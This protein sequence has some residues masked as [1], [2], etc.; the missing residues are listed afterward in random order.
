[1]V[2]HFKL[3]GTQIDANLNDA[4]SVHLKSED[5]SEANLLEDNIDHDNIETSCRHYGYRIRSNSDQSVMDS[6]F[7]HGLHIKENCKDTSKNI[8]KMLPTGPLDDSAISYASA[9]MTTPKKKNQD[10]TINN[11]ENSEIYQSSDN[12]QETDTSDE[13]LVGL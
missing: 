13:S 4:S 12:S 10:Y 9:F 3:T 7:S 6:Q 5:A 2:K 8:R 1:M 11:F